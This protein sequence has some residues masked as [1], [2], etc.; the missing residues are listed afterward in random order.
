MSGRSPVA[1]LP[2]ALVA[3]ASLGCGGRAVSSSSSHALDG[4]AGL[5][6]EACV[7]RWLT[8]RGFDVF[9]SPADTIYPGGS[10]AFDERTGRA[11]SRLELVYALHPDARRDCGRPRR[12]P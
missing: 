1:R 11:V 10:P 5:S 2:L 7:D 4:G 9:G 6:E 8:S 3:L 12:Q